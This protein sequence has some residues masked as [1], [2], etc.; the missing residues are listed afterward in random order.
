MKSAVSAS[1][2]FLAMLENHHE[3]TGDQ[4]KAARALLGLSAQKV[5]DAAGVDLS[6]VQRFELGK[7]KPMPIVRRSIVGALKAAGVEF[8]PGGAKLAGARK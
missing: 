3:H 7:T 6:T 8:V 2:K 5:A 4:I 1:R